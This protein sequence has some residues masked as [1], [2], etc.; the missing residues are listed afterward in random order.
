M[1]KIFVLGFTMMILLSTSIRMLQQGVQIQPVTK[2][3][4]TSSNESSNESI[5]RTTPKK[6]LCEKNKSGL[7]T[8]SKACETIPD[9]TPTG[10][11][12]EH[13][14]VTTEANP[15]T[16]QQKTVE[17][18]TMK[19]TLF[20]GDSRTVGLSEYGNLT[21]ADFFCSTGLNV[22]DLEKEVVTIPNVGHTTLANLLSSK[23]YHKIY[24]MLGINELGYDRDQT[25]N[26]Y[27]KAI[28]Q[29]QNA[30]PEAILFIEANLHVSTSRS[31][32]DGIYNNSNINQFNEQI[33][34]LANNKDCFY[35]DVN[36]LFDDAQ[37]GLSSDKTSDDTH[38]Y[39][40][41]YAE[42]GRWIIEETTNCF[43]ANNI[44]L[45]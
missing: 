28:Q 38:P 1:K 2:Q 35:I 45:T 37:G 25:V 4:Q 36:P 3:I 22:Y 13:A 9:Q 21:D 17:S 24:V 14:D 23:Q 33:A 8:S 5:N 19:D 15:S 34:K 30:Q 18:V 44:Q 7:V 26:A 12:Q 40:K 16:E 42:W 43:E 20:I 6:E 41:Y 10:T 27:R 31:S 11:N 29:I 32:S 39:A